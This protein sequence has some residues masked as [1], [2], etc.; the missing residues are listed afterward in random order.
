V[1]DSPSATSRSGFRSDIEGMR[2]IAVVLVLIYHAGATWLPGG[3]IGVDVFF[4]LSG[5]LITHGLVTELERR[6]TVSLR[7]FYAR[8]FR[9]LLP[10]GTVVL[11]ATVLTAR[12]V[13]S[14]MVAE[15]V[16][17]DG[18][19]AA[20]WL[21]NY[22]FV[23]VGLD[24][25][26]TDMAESPLLHYWSLAV[27]EQFYVVWP[28]LVLAI[29]KLAGRGRRPLI[30]G[31]GTL[32]L[33]SFAWAVFD[34]VNNPTLAYLSLHTRAWEMA[35][36]ALLALTGWRLAGRTAAPLAWGAIVAVVASAAIF[37]ATTS[38]PGPWAA[39]P[40]LGTVVMIAAGTAR[41]NPARRLLDLAPLQ[42][43]GKL[44]YSLYLWHWPVLVLAEHA[45]RRPLT[46]VEAVA[47]LALSWL[48]SEVS[49]VL[50]ENPVR[51]AA[52]LLRS[53]GR[54]LSMGGS[55]AAASLAISLVAATWAPSLTGRGEADW[56][57]LAAMEVFGATSTDVV[58]K[59]PQGADAGTPP[60]VAALQESLD[61]IM[62]QSGRLDAVPA[63]LTPALDEAGDVLPAIYPDECMT[64]GVEPPECVYGDLDAD[65]TMVLFG[66]S[67]AAHWFPP[68]EAAATAHG[69]RL[70]VIA[71]GGCPSAQIVI[72]RDGNRGDACDVWRDNALDRIARERPELVVVSNASHYEA[73]TY[74][75]ARLT[76]QDAA[77][78]AEG[79]AIVT[80]RIH[81]RVPDARV[82]AFGPSARLPFVAPECLVRSLDEPGECTQARDDV[83]KQDLIDL[84]RAAA[85]ATGAEFVDTTRWTCNHEVCPLV[86]GDLLVYWDTHHLTVD[87]STWLT[88]IVAATLFD[89]TADT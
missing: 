37:D 79:Q 4:V 71:K 47:C 66:D 67:H 9:R 80:D 59:P 64:P 1:K 81:E 6:G 82:V 13:A 51:H 75:G 5:F 33:V 35:A 70:V 8:R 84:Q 38:F 41:T 26:A 78:L 56:Q 83:V 53:P 72:W 10:A 29:V 87:F 48:L 32:S 54:S 18:I 74:E 31:L 62:G 89:E 36:G 61:W 21:A 23:A 86:V 27:E 14:P 49:F 40:V 58:G 34:S 77:N 55:L 11:L 85:D 42:R 39:V 44:S 12:V 19:W 24:Y 16:A 22:R 68:I 65:R 7:G 88:P 60:T 2:G 45:L 63:D 28:L 50:V 20:G 69:W 15:S 57:V 30:I 43:A 76:G 3:Y 52:P 25:L 17:I 73:Y 46:A